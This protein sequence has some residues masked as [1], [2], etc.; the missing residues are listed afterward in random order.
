MT[1]ILNMHKGYALHLSVH[2][3][4]IEAT[5]KHCCNGMAQNQKPTTRLTYRTLLADV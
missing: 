2:C 1:Q 4:R 3:L 5:M